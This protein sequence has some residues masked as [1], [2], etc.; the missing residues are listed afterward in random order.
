MASG[1]QRKSLSIEDKLKIIK[2][3]ASN[4]QRQLAISFGVG[5]SQVQRV[6]KRKAEIIEEFERNGNL[7]RKRLCVTGEFDDVDQLTWTW[8]ELAR[9][10]NTPVSGP[11]IQEQAR[12]FAVRLDKPQFSASNGWL[13]RFKNRHNIVGSTLTGERA[14]VEPATVES[15]VLERLPEIVSGYAAC[16]VYNMDETGLLFRAL[17]D[18]SLSVK[19][20]DCAGGKKSKDRLTVALCVNALGEFETPPVIGRSLRPRCFKS[21]QL[22]QLP[23]A[24]VANKKA[25]MTR[26]IFDPWIRRFNGKMSSQG[27]KVLLFL[28]NAS[29]HSHNLDLSNVKIQ[30][31]P[32]NTTSVL[33]PLDLGKIQNMKCHY[34]SQILRSVL[35]KIDLSAS[36]TEIAKSITVLDACHWIKTAVSK[37]NPETVQKCFH[38]AGFEFQ[39]EDTFSGDTSQANPSDETHGLEE[40]LSLAVS[41]LDLADPLSSQSYANIDDDIQTTDALEDGWEDGLVEDFLAAREKTVEVDEEGEE[42]VTEI[43][44]EISTYPDAIKCANDL[45]Q[46]AVL[47]GLDSILSDVLSIQRKLEDAS[48]R[49]RQSAK[50]TSIDS[51]CQRL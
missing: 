23:V 44:P 26:D 11:M 48:F 34:R 38:K 32:A 24:W 28:D 15:W 41:T 12:K 36:A 31:L 25:W 33:Q 18:K 43:F 17:P 6:L 5:K 27:R 7:K 3:S 42:D 40:I 35:S 13:A 50:Q 46:F 10:K 19:G 22:H 14:S 1:K 39:Q 16:D 30:F 51:Y 4:S 45:K 49:Q 2:E 37:I 29:S 8:F 47:K 9:S 20:R 21:L